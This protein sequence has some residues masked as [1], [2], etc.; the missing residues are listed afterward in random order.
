MELV[1]NHEG[2]E[3]NLVE[4]NCVM[5]GAQYIFRFPNGY[6]A[7]VVKHDFSYGHED[8]LWELAVT[9]YENSS[10]DAEWDL[11]YDTPITADVE[12]FLTD[13]MVRDLL[14]KIKGL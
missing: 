8:D 7:S 3:D 4:T 5:N 1:L 10:A 11:C 2:Y 6:G 12:G 9:K 13:E 14:G